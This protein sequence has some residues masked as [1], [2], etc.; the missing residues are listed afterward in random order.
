VR[1]CNCEKNS[2][3]VATVKSYVHLSMKWWDCSQ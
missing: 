2:K 1:E 3:T